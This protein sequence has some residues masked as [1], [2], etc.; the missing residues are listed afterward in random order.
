MTT[1]LDLFRDKVIQAVIRHYNEIADQK[2]VR[3]IINDFC[4]QI[5]DIQDERDAEIAEEES[6]EELLPIDRI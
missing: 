6:E 2:I 1:N 4:E 3:S 5:D